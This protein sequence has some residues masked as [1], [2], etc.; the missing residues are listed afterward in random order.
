MDT[1]LWT[2]VDLRVGR[3]WGVSATLARLIL[4]R[5]Y[6]G[7]LQLGQL[8]PGCVAPIELKTPLQ[9]ALSR[10]VII[11]ETTA[12]FQ[13]GQQINRRPHRLLPFA[14][15]IRH[16]NAQKDQTCHQTSP[17]LRHLGRRLSSPS[18]DQVF[19]FSC[20]Q[21]PPDVSDKPSVSSPVSIPRTNSLSCFVY[22]MACSV[23]SLTRVL[24][25]S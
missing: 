23:E 17:D 22:L 10:S 12:K 13:R 4:W 2:F 6:P 7:P 9:L 18:P 8:G 3:Q 21:M 20:F 25:L 24:R 14:T 15:D 1:G 19:R 5:G 11:N 16:L